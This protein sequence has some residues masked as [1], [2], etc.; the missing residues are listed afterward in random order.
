MVNVAARVT[1]VGRAGEI[2]VTEPVA[3]Q[4]GPDVVLH[5]HGLHA[6]RGIERP[7]HLLTV[8]WHP[9]EELP[10]MPAPSDPDGVQ[11]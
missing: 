11:A 5:D 1:A 2:V 6:L 10:T 4:L 9:T 3:D 7:R 8:E